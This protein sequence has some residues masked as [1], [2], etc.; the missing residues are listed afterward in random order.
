MYIQHSPESVATGT[1]LRACHVA[2]ELWK[3]KEWSA[4][5]LFVTIIP[6]L[7]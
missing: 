7:L 3:A 6:R 2:L 4:W 5:D 1:E